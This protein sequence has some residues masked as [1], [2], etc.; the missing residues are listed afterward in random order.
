VHRN[1][2]LQGL[3]VTRPS[4]VRSYLNFPDTSCESRFERRSNVHPGQ[5]SPSLVA[6]RAG[7]VSVLVQNRPQHGPDTGYSSSLGAC[8]RTC[9]CAVLARLGSACHKS[10]DAQS[11]RANHCTACSVAAPS[12]REGKHSCCRQRLLVARSPVL[13]KGFGC[14]NTRRVCQWC[15]AAGRQH[16]LQAPAGI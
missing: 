4:S 9:R 14:S 10:C 16:D 5:S 8:S 13:C 12:S 15:A 7:A 2:C 6:L 1:R 3:V 11:N